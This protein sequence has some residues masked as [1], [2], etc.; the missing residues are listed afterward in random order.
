MN[1]L[2][3]S[4]ILGGLLLLDGL[5]GMA[6]SAELKAIQTR[7]AKD[8]VITL[9]SESGQWNQGKNA[10]VLEFTS[11]TTKQPVDVGKVTLNTNMSMP[12]MAPM[13]AD[14]T[15]SPDKVPGRYLG[16]I[17]FTDSGTR[18]VTIT[19]DGAAGKG[20]TRFSVPVR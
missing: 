11:G 20:S 3:I 8:V 5:T 14:A 9:L 6:R 10:F 18:Q 19:W 13:V 7:K 12:G 1:R 15:L 4:V 17:S 16:T 2:M